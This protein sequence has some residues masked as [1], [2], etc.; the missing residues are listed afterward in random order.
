MRPNMASIPPKRYL[1]PRFEGKPLKSG[2]YPVR[3][4][5]KI[6]IR[7]LHPMAFREA[8]DVISESL[9]LRMAADVFE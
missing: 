5:R 1:Y 9:P 3:F 8:V 4:D 6:P 2:K 7:C